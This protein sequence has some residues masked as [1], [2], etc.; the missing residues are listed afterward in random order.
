M[1]DT[2]PMI[3]VSPAAVPKSD[4]L[5]AD[6]LIAGDITVRIVG[7]HHKAGEQPVTIEIDGRRPYKPCKGMIRVLIEGWGKNGATWIGK[8]LTLYRNPKVKWGGDPVGGIQI[9]AMSDIKAGFVF[10]LTETRGKKVPHHVAKLTP[11]TAAAEGI[12]VKQLQG[13]CLDAVNK[14]GWTPDQ[15]KALLGRPAADVPADERAA[16]VATLKGPPPAPQSA[17]EPE[18]EA[19]QDDDDN[20][21]APF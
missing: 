3:D 13:W 4:Q 10:M 11:P 8:W 14:R 2:E 17:P 19:E 15:V 12:T 7:V 18:P 21:G 20:N 1:N 6:D 16:I 9:K 5:N